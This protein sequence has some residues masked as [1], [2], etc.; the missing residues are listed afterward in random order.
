MYVQ[1]EPK[2]EYVFHQ[3][4]LCV[5]DTDYAHVLCTLGLLTFSVCNID[6]D[7]GGHKDAYQM[8]NNTSFL[9]LKDFSWCKVYK[10]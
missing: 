6:L 5:L 10:Y 4:L 8:A 2:F 3:T 7:M 1:W 9:Q